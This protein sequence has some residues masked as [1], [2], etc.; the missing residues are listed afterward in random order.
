MGQKFKYKDNAF[1][2]SECANATAHVSKAHVCRGCNQKITDE[3]MVEA[4]GTDRVSRSLAS[5]ATLS[6]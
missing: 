2:C 5:R 4:C 1:F 6:A 3:Q